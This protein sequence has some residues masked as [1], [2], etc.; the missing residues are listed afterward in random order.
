MSS[1]QNDIAISVRGVSK[2]Y[3][4]AHDEVEHIT[5]V[6]ATLAWAKNAFRRPKRD[7]FWA[8][9][10]VSFDVPRGEV[11]GIIGGNGAGKSTLLKIMSRITEPTAGEIDIYGRVGSLLEVGTGFHPE[12]TGRENIFLSGA[13]LGMRRKEIERQFDAIVEFAE[14]GEFLDTPV[15]RYSSGMYVRLA[16]A[17]A[18]HLNPEILMIDEVLAVG[19]LAFQRKCLG[20]MGSVAKQGRTILFVSHD[21]SAIQRL[22]TKA[23]LLEKGWLVQYGPT[24]E[25][26]QRY[27]VTRAQQQSNIDLSLTPRGGHLRQQANLLTALCGGD[28]P[29]AWH[30]SFGDEISFDLRVQVHSRLN[31][32]EVELGL[33]TATGFELGS[34]LSSHTTPWEEVAP[35]EYKVRVAYKNTALVPGRYRFGVG[36]RSDRGL[37][38]YLSEAFFFDVVTSERAAQYRVN[39]L[40]GTMISTVD[41]QLRP[42]SA[43]RVE[44][45]A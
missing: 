34:S 2:A 30:F 38:D 22:C 16:F 8:L 44:V 18:A 20:M 14:A 24:N 4:I 9:K 21:M 42:T 33:F 5:A 31:F 28:H 1:N 39:E 3:K 36:I 13:M 7:T 35:G 17:V 26:I 19:D 25:I 6:E 12:L 29:S 32:M 45:P 43:A 23:V 27:L 41:Y 11:V 10:D 15:K 37:E 40:R